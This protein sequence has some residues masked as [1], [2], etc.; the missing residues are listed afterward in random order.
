MLSE[1]LLAEVVWA[2]YMDQIRQNDQ[3]RVTIVSKL[4]TIYLTVYQY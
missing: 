2:D 4:W 3:G 1:D